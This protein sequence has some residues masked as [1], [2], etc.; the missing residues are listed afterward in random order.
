VVGIVLACAV[1]HLRDTKRKKPK[2]N[3]I[4]ATPT[5]FCLSLKE[6]IIHTQTLAMSL[7]LI[8][9]LLFPTYIQHEKRGIAASASDSLCA[10]VDPVYLTATT[11]STGSRRIESSSQRSKR[12]GLHD[13]IS[14]IR[15]KIPDDDVRSIPRGA[16]TY[17]ATR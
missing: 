8:W 11:V 12:H 9:A 17:D 10:I 13:T 5:N 3:K 1:D 4:K 16:G 7:Y 2:E 15:L 14:I 6:R